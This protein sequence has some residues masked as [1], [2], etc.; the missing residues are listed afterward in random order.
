MAG[1]IEAV[2]RRMTKGPGQPRPCPQLPRQL[3]T[4]VLAGMIMR[5]KSQCGTTVPRPLKSK[6]SSHAGLRA[7]GV[8]R[9]AGDR[10]HGV[11]RASG[12]ARL[13]RS[14]AISEGERVRHALS[15]VRSAACTSLHGFYQAA[16]SPSSKNSH[17]PASI[18][19]SKTQLSLV[20]ANL[21]RST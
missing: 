12:G 1:A 11:P 5:R 20:K 4:T 19:A 14:C 7:R 8:C 9:G 21:I 6:T 17:R 15:C 13:S 3:K 18:H 2:I 16:R 10:L